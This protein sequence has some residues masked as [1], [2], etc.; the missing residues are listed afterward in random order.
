MKAQLLSATLLSAFSG[1]LAAADPTLLNLVMP[2]AKVV[3][4]VNVEQAKGTPFGQWVLNQIQSKDADMQKLVTLT[5]FDPRRDVREVLVATNGSAQSKTGL[6]LARGNFDIA[7]ITA[8]A[9]AAGKDV[10]SETYAGVTILEDAKATHGIAFL[11][12]TTVVAGDLASVKAAIDRRSGSPSLPAAATVKINQWS[13]A[14]D[15]WGISLVSPSSLA[16][17]QAATPQHPN[18]MFAAAQNVQQAFGGIKFGDNVV[19]SAQ[20][21]CDTAQNATALGDVVKFFINL[22]QMQAQQQPQAKALINAVTVT[23][24]GTSL[25]ISAS[26]PE[27]VFIQMLESGKQHAAPGAAGNVPR[28]HTGGPEN[29]K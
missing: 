15:A 27:D 10:A 2:D 4:G 18:P 14:Q 29:R 12:S 8:A 7:K 23:P 11:D 26:L 17:A 3:A 24:N 22:A 19:M 25:N 28:R 9:T 5:G 13:N 1:V 20:A 21:L 16:P 6:A